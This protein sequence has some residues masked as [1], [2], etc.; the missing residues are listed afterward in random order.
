MAT[1]RQRLA[2]QQNARKST[3]PKTTDGKERS[4][5]N[6][7]KDGLTGSGKVL[8][9]NDDRKLRK[10]LKAWREQLQPVGVLEESL[11]TRAALSNVRLQRCVK[12]DLAD[13]ARRRRRATA[14]WDQRQQHKLNVCIDLIEQNPRDAVAH[15]EASSLGCE[16]MIAQWQGLAK[17]LEEPGFWSPEQAAR[18]IRLRG[19]D[20]ATAPMDDSSLTK[21]R[22]GTLAAAPEVDPDEADA[23]FEEST[24]N[25][26]PEARIR[27][28]SQKLPEPEFGRAMLQ[29]IIDEELSRLEPLR[30][31]LWEEQD[32]PARQEAEDLSLVDTS[33]AGARSLRYETSHELSLHRNLN[34]LVRLRKI[35]PEQQTF[36]RWSKAGIN[37]GRIWRGT[38]WEYLSAEGNRE[39]AQN[40]Q[41]AVP[42]A[43]SPPMMGPKY[44]VPPDAPA[45]QVEAG[46]AKAAASALS[47]AVSTVSERP[48]TAASTVKPAVRNEAKISDANGSRKSVC[49]DRDAGS[50]TVSAASQGG[51][52]G[53]LPQREERPRGLATPR[54][55]R[56]CNSR[57]LDYGVFLTD[58]R[59]GAGKT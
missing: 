19:K 58:P 16:W 42:V 11:V 1:E 21:L 27:K 24:A 17:L 28:L 33:A 48:A 54:P 32:A 22:L 3:G 43:A 29:D 5:R 41:R 8:K 34:Q 45:E 39:G 49:D 30:E 20:P 14:R 55:P 44:E 35:E 13:V 31:E 18:A 15:L 10:A 57:G 9:R 50:P 12:H 46:D 4:R 26:N 56:P 36:T 53:C 40:A 47:A 23:F 37:Q 51:G 7:L 25:L 59:A 2:N 6:A 52:P 38:G